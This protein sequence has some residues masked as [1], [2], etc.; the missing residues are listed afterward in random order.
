MTTT[1][2]LFPTAW[3][4]MA[5]FFICSSSC[6]LEDLL[7][8]VL[9]REGGHV[10]LLGIPDALRVRHRGPGHDG[11]VAEARAPEVA[12]EAVLGA[13]V[14]PAGGLLDEAQ[15]LLRV[16]RIGLR[17]PFPRV[18]LRLVDRLLPDDGVEVVPAAGHVTRW[19]GGAVALGV[20]HDVAVGLHVVLEM[21]RHLHLRA[22][23]HP[24]R[25]PVLVSIAEHGGGKLDA[26]GVHAQRLLHRLLDLREHL[27]GVVHANGAG[28]DAQRL[29]QPR[30]SAGLDAGDQGAAQVQRRPVR[31]LVM[32]GFAKTLPGCHVN[33]PREENHRGAAAVPQGCARTALVR[34]ALTGTA[35][36]AALRAVCAWSPY[37]IGPAGT[38]A[39]KR[40]YR[41]SD[42]V[43]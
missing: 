15:L 3:R 26:E 35:P 12:Q 10:P 25:F 22:V 31:L 36:D 13:L 17:H 29:L 42:D 40:G 6:R 9:A 27:V 8:V 33:L 4:Y 28:R 21:A 37:R 20:L 5:R 39:Q 1:S 43:H 2:I 19:R 34:L 7:H 18:Q 32:N 14:P 11:D 41:P 30:V 24:E 16:Q 23:E 38:D